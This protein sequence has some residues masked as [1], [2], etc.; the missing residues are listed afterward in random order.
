MQSRSTG[1]CRNR[2]ELTLARNACDL[3][4]GLAGDVDDQMVGRRDF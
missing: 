4:S 1:S 2:Y 3:E